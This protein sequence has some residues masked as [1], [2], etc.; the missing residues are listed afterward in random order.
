MKDLAKK[1]LAGVVPTLAQARRLSDEELVERLVSVR[2][3]GV[4]S[5]EMF[6][7]FRLGRPD[8]LPVHDLG[9]RKG[10]SVTYGKP[11]MP[12]ARELLA[13]SLVHLV[14]LRHV[15]S[16]AR[17]DIAQVFCFENRGEEIGVTQHHPHGQIYAYP[18]VVPRTAR[19]IAAAVAHRRRHGRNLFDDL[20]AAE[21]ADAARVVSANDHWVAFVPFAARWPY[22]LHLYP[23]VRVPD[24]PWVWDSSPSELM[25]FQLSVALQQPLGSA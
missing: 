2:G 6:L 4:W 3:I 11:H 7:I 12:T 5:V 23:R 10:W 21:L 17:G 25:A 18:V 9:V 13:F 14:A 20:V 8:V 15:V 19:M 22:E 24:L 16:S 1:T